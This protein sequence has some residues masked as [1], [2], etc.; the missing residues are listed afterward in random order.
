MAATPAGRALTAEHRAAQAA[1]RVRLAADTAVAWR[2]LDMADL[3]ATT[4]GWL[5]VML[6][7]VGVHR[8]ASARTSA[9]YYAEHRVAELADTR[10]E[11]PPAPELR[12]ERHAKPDRNTVTTSLLVTG[13][14]AVKAA[15]A[16]GVP[17]QDASRTALSRV[18]GAAARHAL[19]GGR[20]VL[21]QAVTADARALGWIRVTDADPCH[22]CAMLAS[23]GPVYKDRNA[24]LWRDGDAGQRFHDG[25]ACTVEPVYDADAPWPGRAAEFAELWKRS[26]AGLSGDAARRAFRRA[27]TEHSGTGSGTGTDRDQAPGARPAEPVPD[28]P[29]A[30]PAALADPDGASERNG[31]DL[32]GLTDEELAD[33]FATESAS[34]DADPEVL[35]RLLA[36]MDRRDAPAEDPDPLA[37][38][39]L[40]TLPVFELFDLWRAYPTHSSAVDRI[41]AEL[42]RRD[43]GGTVDAPED[44][45]APED[46][47]LVAETL[48][49]LDADLDAAAATR[50]EQ[51]AREATERAD[52]E[53]Q[54]EIDARIDALIAR[55]WDYAEAYA[56]VFQLDAEELRR[57]E[58][59]AAV[60]A[61]RRAGETRDQ[62]ARRLY[63][64]WVY[65]EWIA[66]EEASNGFLLNAAG[67][68]A[69][70]DPRELWGGNVERARRY[71]SEELKR[72]WAERPRKTFTEFKAELLGRD[73]DVQAAARSRG[74]GNDKDFG[75]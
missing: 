59:A 8:A 54:A 45:Q 73:R 57:Q 48:A 34:D 74:R 69:G 61:Q 10:G 9:R 49:E 15:T 53:R 23:R 51:E 25:C 64:E 17:E 50:A 16:R 56:E 42:D 33:A 26:T 35:D 27:L 72:W 37:G 65:L 70:I 3:D 60:D 43:R 71:A 46:G 32:S 4:P 19:E 38:L 58:R 2:L 6:A 18:T 31:G 52:R 55:G 28:V 5:A 44:D 62:A 63:D 40:S 67:V 47:P 21:R 12:P 14:S 24:A 1:I 20:S 22:F 36:E 66:A 39:D 11:V 7:L 68:A 13:P 30:V 29:S 41:G 75:L